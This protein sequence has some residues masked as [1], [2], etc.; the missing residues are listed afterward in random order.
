MIVLEC[1]LKLANIVVSLHFHELLQSI[2]DL[3]MLAVVLVLA[4]VFILHRI[5]ELGSLIIAPVFETLDVE[6]SHHVVILMNEV[7]A[8][9]HVDTIVRGV[10]RNDCDLLVHAQENDIFESFL[11]VVEDRTLTTSA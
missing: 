7:V 1:L 11:F 8:M 3:I 10:A 4:A 5:K 9:E 2:G 6:G